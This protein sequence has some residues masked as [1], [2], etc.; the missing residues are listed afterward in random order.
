MTPTTKQNDWFTCTSAEPYDRH[1]YTI[2]NK[3]FD[4]YTVMRSYWMQNHFA[5]GQT[6]IVHDYTTGKRVSGG[7]GFWMISPPWW[8]TLEI[9]KKIYH[10][11]SK[12]TVKVLWRRWLSTQPIE[13]QAKVDRTQSGT[14][15]LR[16]PSQC[17]ILLSW[18][19]R[20]SKVSKNSEI[21]VFDFFDFL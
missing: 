20:N 13:S 9:C 12:D 8:T 19:Q 21:S 6:V 3:R 4:D 10:G 16:I 11:S 14:Q 5:K 1:Y 7:Q 2:N 15:T 17:L 18:K